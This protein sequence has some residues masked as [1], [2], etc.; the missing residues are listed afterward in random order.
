[1]NSRILEFYGI[2][3]GVGVGASGVGVGVVSGAMP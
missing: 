2:Y 3:V 1:M